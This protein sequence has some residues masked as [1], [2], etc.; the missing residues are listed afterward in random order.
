MHERKEHG[1]QRC[2]HRPSVGD[3]Q[4]FHFR[5]TSGLCYAPLRQ[6]GHDNDWQNNFIGR[7]SQNE[8]KQN[9]AV[10]PHE[11]G[12]RVKKTGADGEQTC[13]VHRYICKNPQN[14]A[15]GSGDGGRPAQYKKRALHDGT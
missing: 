14:H 6:I 11:P 1:A 13:S 4:R 7:Q 15:G 9:Y 3:E 2:G 10:K 12:K 8:C 5:Q